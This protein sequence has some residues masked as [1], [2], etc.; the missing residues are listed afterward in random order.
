MQVTETNQEGLTRAFRVVIPAVEIEPKIDD[1]LAQLGRTL[2]LPGFR[3]G[4]VP[5][6]LIRK[7]HGDEV[8]REVVGTAIEDAVTQ[9]LNE[10]G[11]RRASTPEIEF[12]PRE[13]G[14]D[15]EFNLSV[16]VLPEIE[17]CDPATLTLERLVVS[18]TDREVGA[19]IARLADSRGSL[20][21]IDEDRPAAEGDLVE[22]DVA[23]T[24][25][26]ADVPRLSGTGEAL[27]LGDRGVPGFDDQVIGMTAG[28]AKAFTLTL[29]DDFHATDLAGAEI[30]FEVTVKR[31]CRREPA[32]VDDALARAIGADTLAD[33]RTQLTV[34]F[35]REFGRAARQLIKRAL[36]DQLAAR[37]NFPVPSGMRD[38]EFQGIWD[39]IEQ[40]R[41]KGTL[42]PAD[43]ARD[44]EELKA[45]YRAIAE[46]RIRLGLLLAEIGRRNNLAV[47]EAELDR[48][49]MTQAQ[50]YSGEQRDRLLALRGQPEVLEQLRAPL[51]EE[52]V[53]DFILEL[54]HV[55]ER[56]VTADELRAMLDRD[57]DGDDALG[58]TSP[59]AGDASAVDRVAGMNGQS[60]RGREQ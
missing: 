46:R 24:R 8:T 17:P 45:E 55:T 60:A 5:K 20:V 42:S 7:R 49:L 44:P 33:L 58:A 21:S 36:L 34:G 40:G 6:G 13:A 29:P 52:K 54:A 56:M 11:L 31:L 32:A 2:R 18:D 4:K 57:D 37:H 23:A 59:A 10:R 12:L 25:N 39:A 41:A 38:A 16:E 27:R 9:T 47:S 28:T 14:G 50:Q 22:V 43:A 3:P 48:A 35:G 53:V 30:A 26:G 19:A 1:R 15:L 51:F